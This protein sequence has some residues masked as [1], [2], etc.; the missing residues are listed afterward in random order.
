MDKYDL[1]LCTEISILDYINNNADHFKP[2]Q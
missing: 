1:L 2:K